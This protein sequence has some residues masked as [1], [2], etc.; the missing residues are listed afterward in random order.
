[1]PPG[2]IRSS[3]VLEDSRREIGAQHLHTPEMDVVRGSDGTPVDV[4]E[5]VGQIGAE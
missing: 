2:A 5:C 1:M 3:G 4:V